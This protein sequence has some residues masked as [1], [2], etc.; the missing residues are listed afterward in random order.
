[1][2]AKRQQDLWAIA[3]ENSQ[4]AVRSARQGNHLKAGKRKRSG[5]P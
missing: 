1:M 3:V 2:D 5:K 4:A